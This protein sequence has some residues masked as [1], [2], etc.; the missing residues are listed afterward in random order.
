MYFY[1][2][3]GEL[4]V[5]LVK[6]LKQHYAGKETLL[7]E[8]LRPSTRDQ[9][10]QKYNELK[11]GNAEVDLFQHL[12]LS[13]IFKLVYTNE[14]LRESLKI[15]SRSQGEKLFG[16]IDDLRNQIMHPTRFLIQKLPDDLLKLNERV[17]RISFVLNTIK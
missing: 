12:Y 7:L 14:N 3:I 16:G 15:S 10:I 11:A 5:E 1:N 8:S 13:D 4:E 6:L 2:L 17:Q 9:I